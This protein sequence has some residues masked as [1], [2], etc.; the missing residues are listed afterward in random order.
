MQ[1]IAIF[2]EPIA[3]EMASDAGVANRTDSTYVL[4]DNVLLIRS[5]AYTP[6]AMSDIMGFDDKQRVGVLFKLNGSYKGYQTEELWSWLAEKRE[7]VS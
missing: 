5:H 6:E 3:E 2:N 7:Y 1:Y 4:A